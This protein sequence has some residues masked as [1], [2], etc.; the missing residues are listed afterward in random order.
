MPTTILEDHL[1]WRLEKHWGY[2][3]FGAPVW[4]V[5]MEEGLSNGGED[6]LPTRFAAT[7]G[8]ILAD[9]RR[10]MNNVKDH[11][12][13]FTRRSTKIPYKIQPYWSYPISFYL[14]VVLGREPTKYEKSIFQGEKLGSES[15]CVLELMPLPSNKTNEATW[16]YGKYGSFGLGTRSQYLERYKHARVRR[17]KELIQN[18]Q[19]RL[20]I[21]NSVLYLPDWEAACGGKLSRAA[22]QMYFLM[23]ERTMFCVLPQ[24]HP[25]M[26]YARVYEFAE[27]IRA[28]GVAVSARSI[29]EAV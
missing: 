21:F 10:D 8:K 1:R 17:L 26:S 27:R 25:G 14:Y 20:V 23:G 15:S 16:Q 2:G 5:G 22:R 3:S 7:N 28:A 4:F 11:M 24:N 13:W 18:H 6:Y 29:F 19:P 9:I 12:I